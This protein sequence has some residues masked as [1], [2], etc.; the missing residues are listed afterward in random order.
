[1]EYK[2]LEQIANY[3]PGIIFAKSSDG[4]FIYA[5][6]EYERLFQI[7]KDWLIGKTN[8]DFMPRGSCQKTSWQ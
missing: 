2:V 3:I 6:Q 4:K 7:K 5:N 1:M 8:F